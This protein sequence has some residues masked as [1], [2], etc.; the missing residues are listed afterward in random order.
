MGTLRTALGQILADTGQRIERIDP[1]V[2]QGVRWRWVRWGRPE[3]EAGRDRE[4]SMRTLRPVGDVAVYGTGEEQL[5]RIIEIE[6]WYRGSDDLVERMASDERDIEA[7]L[8]PSSTYPSG[9]WGALRVRRVMREAV[10]VREVLDRG[11]AVQLVIPVTVIW[12]ESVTLA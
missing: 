12:R 7:A 5:G 2:H 8:T 9:S 4:F 11:R 6:A 3:G 10:E 1:T